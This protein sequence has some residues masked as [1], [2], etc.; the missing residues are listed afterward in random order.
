MRAGSK[1][2]ESTPLLGD[3]FLIS[4]MM[5]GSTGGEGG[6]EIAAPGE[7]QFGLALP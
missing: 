2:A 3:A 5:A 7:A 1:S 6:A 4:A